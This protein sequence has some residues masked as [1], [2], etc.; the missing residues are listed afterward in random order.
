MRDFTQ[1]RFSFIGFYCFLP[2]EHNPLHSLVW[3]LTRLGEMNNK[4]Y[5]HSL[6][7]R[8]NTITPVP[9]T[10]LR[11]ILAAS[12]L[13]YFFWRS[14]ISYHHSGVQWQAKK[15][16]SL[17]GSKLFLIL[18]FIRAFLA[19]NHVAHLWK[20]QLSITSRSRIFEC[21]HQKIVFFQPSD[22]HEYYSRVTWAVVWMAISQHD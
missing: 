12:R 15:K 13:P 2:A 6:V 4:L 9:A 19:W 11:C 3:A 21:G 1:Q 20:W 8:G 14:K 10:T 16:K 18:N 7:G 17:G 22:L 5:L